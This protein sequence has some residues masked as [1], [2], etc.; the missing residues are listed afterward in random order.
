MNRQF[1][2]NLLPGTLLFS[3]FSLLRCLAAGEAGGVYLVRD[4]LRANELVAIKILSSTADI[5][6]S[7]SSSLLRELSISRQVNHPNVLQGSEFFRDDEFAAFTMEYIDGG[8]LA[9]RLESR[10][11]FRLTSAIRVL[12]QICDGL[13]AIHAAG[14]VHRD[15]K[16]DNILLTSTQNVKIADFGISAS[17]QTSHANTRDSISGSLNYLSPEYVATGNYDV[18]SDIYAIGVIAYELVTGHLPF[19]G[20]SLMEILMQRVRFDPP[21]PHSFTAHVPRPLSHAI[22]KAMDRNPARRFQSLDEVREAFDFIKLPN[23]TSLATRWA[24]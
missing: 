6:E 7:L 10:E 5:D 14:I 16:P 4:T 24:A 11:P 19:G 13:R 20:K 18:R 3:R 22:L 17:D 21:A 8:S 1:Y 9:D 2:A 23:G 12:S 15:I